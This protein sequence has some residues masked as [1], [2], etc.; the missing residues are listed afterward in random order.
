MLEEK[1]KFSPPPNKI[2]YLWFLVLCKVFQSSGKDA[3]NCQNGS[4]FGRKKSSQTISSLEFTFNTEPMTVYSTVLLTCTRVQLPPSCLEK[5]MINL[6]FHYY[7]VESGLCGF[8][9]D[10]LSP[11]E[12]ENTQRILVNFEP[13]F[14]PLFFPCSTLQIQTAGIKSHFGYILIPATID[15]V[16]GKDFGYQIQVQPEELVD[17]VIYAKY[18]YKAGIWETYI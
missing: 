16:F 18:S 14:V 9:S 5:K 11:V 13:S 12:A 4:N 10:R 2:N 15:H 1:L 3:A 6:L 17:I 7:L 8:I